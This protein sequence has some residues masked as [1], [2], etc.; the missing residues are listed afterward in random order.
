MVFALARM[1]VRMAARI[2]MPTGTGSIWGAAITGFMHVETVRSARCDTAQAS[3]DVHAARHGGQRQRARGGIAFGRRHFRTQARSNPR[4]RRSRRSW[5]RCRFCRSRWRGRWRWISG[6]RTSH[7]RT[8][9]GKCRSK[10]SDGKVHLIPPCDAEHGDADPP[11]LALQCELTAKPAFTPP[12]RIPPG[13][14]AP[15]AR[16]TP[17]RRSS[18][19]QNRHIPAASRCR[20]RNRETPRPAHRP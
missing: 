13:A 7:R 12:S 11:T 19:R 16:G 4:S 20:A 10:M 6:L 8:R 9:D 15:T 2:E 14:T 3:G 17:A 5:W 18:P 1:T